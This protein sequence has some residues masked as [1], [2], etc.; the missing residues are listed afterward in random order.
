MWR[1]KFPSICTQFCCWRKQLVT[2]WWT[3]VRI[4]AWNMKLSWKA[5]SK[6]ISTRISR[7]IR[8]Y[9]INSLYYCNYQN[10]DITHCPVFHLQHDVSETGFYLRLQVETTQGCTIQRTSLCLRTY[11]AHISMFHMKT[12]TNS[13]LQNVVLYMKDRTMD[14]VMNCDIFINILS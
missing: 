10:L 6:K 7:N 3:I 11:W 14:N 12:E 8:C 1:V 2:S 13:S 5:D 9:K 4:D